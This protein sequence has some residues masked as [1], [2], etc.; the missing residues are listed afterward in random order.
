MCSFPPRWFPPGRTRSHPGSG[1]LYGPPPLYHQIALSDSPSQ[2]RLLPCLSICVSRHF[3][4]ILRAHAQLHSPGRQISQLRL[5]LPQPGLPGGAHIRHK[6]PLPLDRVNV[7][8]PLQLHIGSL[9]GIGVDGQLHRQPSH[10]RQ[11]LILLQNPQEH[12][13]LEPLRHLLIDGPPVLVIQDNHP[14]PS[15]L[16]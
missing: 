16:Y 2:S 13:L 8:L 7:S 1:H 14:L 3:E 9:D 15:Q 5:Q 12:Q 10:R 6:A 11:L 4:E